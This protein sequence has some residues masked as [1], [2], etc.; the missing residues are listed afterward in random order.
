MTERQ[1]PRSWRR[2]ETLLIAVLLIIGV[3]R[4]GPEIRARSGLPLTAP[5]L[6]ILTIGGDTLH[7]A[8]LRGSIVLV[9]FWAT[10][11]APCLTEMPALQ[12]VADAYGDGA[13]TVVGLS[14]DDQPIADFVARMRQQGVTYP[15]AM[16]TPHAVR[17]LGFNGTVPTT[18]VI[19]RE[20]RVADHVI[21]AMSEGQLHERLARHLGD[22]R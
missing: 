16:A 4:Y 12:A 8:D 13:I 1:S 9:N 6:E 7:L 15:L 19:D 14:V 3:A 21:G 18:V 11:C 10:W 20:G 22:T 2:P 5:D 17:G